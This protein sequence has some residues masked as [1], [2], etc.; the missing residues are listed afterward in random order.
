MKTQLL[1]LGSVVLHGVG[2]PEAGAINLIYSVLLHEY[3]QDMYSYIGINQ[4]GNDLDELIMKEPNRRIYINIR[5]PSYN[6]FEKK[7]VIEQNRIRLDVVHQSLLRIAKE[8]DKLDVEKLIMI[9]NK[10][11][12]NNF[13]FDFVYKTYVNKKDESLVAKVIIHP[14]VTRFDI[15]VLIEQNGQAK[16][17]KMIYSGGTDDY[18]FAALFAY[19]MWHN[20]NRFVVSGKE[21]E[22][23]IHID[24]EKCS[25]EYVNSSGYHNK[26]PFFELMKKHRSEKES[27]KAYEDWLHSLPP[28]VAAII[29][30]GYN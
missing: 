23:E 29:N 19:G 10:I 8:D 13:L 9:K 16:C 2:G 5:Y 6:D 1:R 22:M 11:L 14:L 30:Q 20:T 24:I 18:Y 27:D 17:K 28:A 3:N 26:A 15:Y 4:I 7:S 21:K 12:E 25:V